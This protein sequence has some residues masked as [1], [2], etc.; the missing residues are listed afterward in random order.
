VVAGW[1]RPLL[2]H[3][4]RLAELRP[5]LLCVSLAGAASNLSA[6]GPEAPRVIGPFAAALD[7]G[8]PDGPWHNA[9]DTLAEFAGWL[10]LLA[11]SLAKIGEDLILMTQSGIGEVRLPGAGG[12]STM[13]QKRNPVAPS[14]LVALGRFAAAQQGAM[15]A[16]LLHRQQRDGAAWMLEWLVLPQLCLAA[17]RALAVAQD[18]AQGLSPD[19]GRMRAG[20]RAEGGAIF[21]EALVFALARRMPR[22]EAQAAV[23]AL[24]RRA[25]AEGRDLADLAREAWPDAELAAAFDPARQLGQAPAEADSFAAEARA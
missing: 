14:L 23:T 11:G 15:T 13:P 21:A 8:V 19:A 18:L 9:R 7:L 12:S 20:L 10:A 3:R 2:R 4:R 1:G 6:M 16:A 5:R 24:C 22:P 17:A 25:A